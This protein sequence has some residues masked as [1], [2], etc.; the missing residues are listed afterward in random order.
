MPFLEKGWI[1]SVSIITKTKNTREQLVLLETIP[2][3]ILIIRLFHLYI[4]YVHRNEFL[5]I[6]QLR[7]LIA[8]GTFLATGYVLV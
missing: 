7:V 4:P 8:L 1:R 5:Y 3:D 6:T 2:I